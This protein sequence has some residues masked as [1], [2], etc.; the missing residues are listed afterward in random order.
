M[1]K[2]PTF[3]DL[4]RGRRHAFLTFMLCTLGIIW[5]FALTEKDGRKE[6]LKPATNIF[7]KVSFRKGPHNPIADLSHLE[8]HQLSP[9]F[10]YSRRMVKTKHYHGARPEL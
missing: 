8:K 5:F 6:L 4:S 9:Q 1:G 3:F 10:S 7:N 2:P